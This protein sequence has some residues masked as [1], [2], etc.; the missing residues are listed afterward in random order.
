ML[1]F[2]EERPDIERY[3]EGCGPQDVAQRAA[4]L[5]EVLDRVYGRGSPWGRWRWPL[6]VYVKAVLVSVVAVSCR[7]SERGAP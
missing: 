6:A 5:M 7:D 2:S 1:D 3:L 4:L